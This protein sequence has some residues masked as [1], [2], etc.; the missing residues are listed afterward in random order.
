MN[1]LNFLDCHLSC[2]EDSLCLDS[3]FRGCTECRE[4]KT[5]EL[6]SD[7]TSHGVC[8]RNKKYKWKLS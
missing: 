3:T 7:S 8:T 5:L 2:K 4:G 1:N 6:V